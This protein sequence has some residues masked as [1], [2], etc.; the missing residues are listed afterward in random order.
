MRREIK[1]NNLNESLK[2]GEG[3]T[4]FLRKEIPFKS[5]INPSSHPE[6]F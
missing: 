6:I 1:L 2:R 5:S 4:D 3:Q